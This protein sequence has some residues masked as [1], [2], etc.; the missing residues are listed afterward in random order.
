MAASDAY[1]YVYST[2]LRSSPLDPTGTPCSRRV[3]TRPDPPRG[4]IE[5]SGDAI[6]AFASI[7]DRPAAMPRHAAAVLAFTYIGSAR[8]ARASH[9]NRPPGFNHRS[10][11]AMHFQGLRYMRA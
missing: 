9:A 2:V 1:T 6:D 5:P 11:L 7:S 3:P 10:R 4:S 8:N